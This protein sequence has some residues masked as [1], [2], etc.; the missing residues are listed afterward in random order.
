MRKYVYALCSNCKGEIRNMLDYY[1]APE[2]GLSGSD[3]QR[4]GGSG[5]TVHRV[6]VPLILFSVVFYSPIFNLFKL[7]EKVLDIQIKLF[8]ILFKNIFPQWMD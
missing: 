8:E 7:V 2:K 5:R 4:N 6:G 3:G 1:N